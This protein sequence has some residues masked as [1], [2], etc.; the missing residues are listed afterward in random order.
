MLKINLLPPKRHRIVLGRTGEVIL[1][2]I[3]CV[4]VFCLVCMLL[5]GLPFLL[6]YALI[7][8]LID[9]LMRK[10]FLKPVFRKRMLRQLKMG[11][12]IRR[13]PTE[14]RGPA[15]RYK[16]VDLS[17]IDEDIVGIE[18]EWGRQEERDIFTL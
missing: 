1:N 12:T 5:L 3:A 4:L 6:P 15:E 10:G 7:A 9:H 17:R 13:M 2:V 8:G 14:Y 11:R 18:W 16:I